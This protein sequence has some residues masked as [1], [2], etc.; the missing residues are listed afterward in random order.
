MPMLRFC[1]HLVVWKQTL[2]SGTDFEAH[3]LSVTELE[4]LKM[5]I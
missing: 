5:Y 3:I 1:A 2:Q 4:R